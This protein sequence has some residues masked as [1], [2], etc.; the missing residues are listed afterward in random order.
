MDSFRK[1]L[2]RL[3][4]AHD[5]PLTM[6]QA[7]HFV[8]V[9]ESTYREWEYGRKIRGVEPYVK[10]AKAFGVSLDEL[11]G[12]ENAPESSIEQ[13]IEDII[14]RLASLKKKVSKK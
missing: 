5:P 14:S 9:P 4:E 12:A 2:K 11:L 7:A 13:D 8:G 3:R 6:R 10:I 1:R